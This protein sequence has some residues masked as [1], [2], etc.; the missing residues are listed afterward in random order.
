MSA[1]VCLQT[2]VAFH[3]SC[4][5]CC[6]VLKHLVGVSN[7]VNSKAGIWI[8]L[9][10]LLRERR[11]QIFLGVR[12]LETRYSDMADSFSPSVC[13]FVLFFVFNSSS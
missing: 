12:T 4:S 7:L 13:L 8:Y 5:E 6:F 9:D 10:F 11:Y 1:L 2:S 3:F